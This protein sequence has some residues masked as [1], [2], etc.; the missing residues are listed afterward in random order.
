MAHGGGC[1]LLPLLRLCPMLLLLVH[2]P[3]VIWR[4]LLLYCVQCR[5]LLLPLLSHL[6]LL[7]LVHWPQVIWRG[8]LLHCVQCR[9]LL[10]P[11]PSHLPLLLLLL[12]LLHHPLLLLTALLLH[13]LLHS[14][15]Q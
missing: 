15:L 14:A 2:W 3:Q 13:L 11:L 7:L 9:L 12:L 8:R 10:L 6:P 5:L 1:I 4:G